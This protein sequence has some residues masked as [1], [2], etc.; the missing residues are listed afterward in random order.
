MQGD[1]VQGPKSDEFITD[2]SVG[3]PMFSLFL[4]TVG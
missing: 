4:L 3:P 1:H 2:L